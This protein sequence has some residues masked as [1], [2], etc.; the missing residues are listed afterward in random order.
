MYTESL[1]LYTNGRILDLGLDGLVDIVYSPPNHALQTS[2][3]GGFSLLG[4]GRRDLSLT[5]HRYL[6]AG[7]KKPNPEVLKDILKETGANVSTALYVGDS[8]LKDIA[9]ARD[10]GVLDVLASYGGVQH[11]SEYNVLRE[12]SHWS[13]ADV[14]KERSQIQLHPSVSIDRFQDILEYFQ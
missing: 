7:V 8:L 13:D 12:V 5:E 11:K 14:E 6:P 2:Q 4:G 9:M 3:G 1:E 10:V